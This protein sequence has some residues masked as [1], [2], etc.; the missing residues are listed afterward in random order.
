M[1]ILIGVTLGL[2]TFRVAPWEHYENCRGWTEN[3][4][5]ADLGIMKFFFHV[6]TN[7]LGILPTDLCLVINLSFQDSVPNL[8]NS[9]ANIFMIK[10][11]I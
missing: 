2:C 4:P 3:V 1:T 9:E 11:F 5:N 10:F 6:W 8:F 7:F